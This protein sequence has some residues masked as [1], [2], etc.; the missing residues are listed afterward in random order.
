[1]SDK[2][3]PYDTAYL[4]KLVRE[5]GFICDIRCW[6]EGITKQAFFKLWNTGFKTLPSAPGENGRWWNA[7]HFAYAI[8]YAKEHGTADPEAVWDCISKN[9]EKHLRHQ[10]DVWRNDSIR[11][12]RNSLDHASRGGHEFAKQ[13]DKRA[14]ESWNAMNSC[15]RELGLPEEQMAS[16]ATEVSE[17]SKKES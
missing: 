11:G 15:L 5:D 4:E 1:M 13:L 12:I 14:R 10:I 2:I 8:D 16:V 3:D 17:S 9:K 7:G 6:P